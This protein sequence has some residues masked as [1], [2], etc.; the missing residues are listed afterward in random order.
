MT[1]A[2]EKP[3]DSVRLSD[4]ELIRAQYWQRKGHTLSEIAAL[5]STDRKRVVTSLYRDVVLRR[6]PSR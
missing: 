3:A 2:L 6:R 4:A 1:I 5:L